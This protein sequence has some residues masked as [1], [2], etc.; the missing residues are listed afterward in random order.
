MVALAAS[1]NWHDALN[2]IEARSAARMAGSGV[3]TAG[4][5]QPKWPRRNRSQV[6]SCELQV[7]NGKIIDRQIIERIFEISK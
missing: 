4:W 5:S 7:W 1:A 2:K 3:L 6:E